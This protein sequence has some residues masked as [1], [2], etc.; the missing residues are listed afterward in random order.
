MKTIWEIEF[1]ATSER[2]GII[3]PNICILAETNDI[4]TVKAAVVTWLAKYNPDYRLI[5]VHS[6]KFKNRV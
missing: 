2:G 3:M 1:E 5:Q 4:E 6:L